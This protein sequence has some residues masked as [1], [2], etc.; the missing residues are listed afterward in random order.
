MRRFGGRVENPPRGGGRR[1]SRRD[2]WRL[3][4]EVLPYRL[5]RFLAVRARP[6]RG[7][8]RF[9]ADQLAPT[10][11]LI[12]ETGGVSHFPNYQGLLARVPRTH[13]PRPRR[14]R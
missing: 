6:P 13:R 10:F 7:T 8:L 3:L 2:R 9:L 1:L 4:V 12:N 11:Y 14:R 5:P